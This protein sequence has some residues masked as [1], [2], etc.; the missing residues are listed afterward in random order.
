MSEENARRLM[1]MLRDAGGT[2]KEPVPLVEI[3]K[4]AEKNGFTDLLEEALVSAASAGWIEDGAPDDGQIQ[5][6]KEG[7]DRGNA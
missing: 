4:L 2:T 7:W 5:I 6:T 1:Q 3:Q